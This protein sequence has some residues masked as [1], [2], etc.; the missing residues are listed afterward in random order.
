M[1]QHDALEGFLDKWRQRWPEWPVAEVFVPA[2]QRELA[3]AWF[4]LLQEFEDA[5]NIAGDPLPADAKLA[6][7]G[8]ELRDWSRRRSRHPLGRLL[9]PRAAPWEGLAE[10]LPTLVEARSQPADGTAAFEGWRSFARA[11]VAVEAALFGEAGAPVAAAPARD[12][13]QTAVVA[14]WLAI[15]WMG[16]G[17]SAV[18][19]APGLAEAA[20][21]GHLRAHWPLR[22]VAAPVPVR[23]RSALLR[24]RLQRFRGLDAGV[25]PLSPLATVWLAWRAARR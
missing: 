1:S 2:P 24:A 13:W 8:E 19:V 9:E 14:Q 25:P 12:A 22:L 17:A 20:W 6:W 7:W 10:A 16:T 21:A 3:V 23:L 18:P 11:Q 15:R 4:A 5:M